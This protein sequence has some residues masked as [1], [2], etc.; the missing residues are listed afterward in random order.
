MADININKD[1]DSKRKQPSSPDDL[2]AEIKQTS[3]Q[4]KARTLSFSSEELN[5]YEINDSKVDKILSRKSGFTFNIQELI[6]GILKD[7]S[8]IDKI[9]PKICQSVCEKLEIKY[10]SLVRDIVKPLEDQ[11]SS[12]AAQIKEQN[13]T[14]D[15]HVQK[16]VDHE[17]MIR[18]QGATIIE[19]K[20]TLFE[21]QKETE[22]LY[23]LNNELEQRLDEQEQYSRRTSLRFHNIPCTD[24]RNVKKMN[25]DQIVLDICNKH[26]GLS[27]SL[28]DIGRT[29]PIG[30][31]RKNKTQVIVRFLSYRQRS[32]VF[33]A[34]SKLKSNQDG[35]FIT[36]NLTSK[37]QAIMDEL[38]Y[39]R[40]NKKIQAC[41]SM[42]GRLFAIGKNC[43]A[44]MLV[45]SFDDNSSSTTE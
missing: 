29:H 24:S 12:Q 5:R 27:M 19:L 28:N 23:I 17:L 35:I 38:N 8:F 1:Y 37:R 26:L 21:L 42:D 32:A 14:I 40:F 9:V 36:E 45:R 6:C 4:T 11:V 7:D 18:D 30:K 34:K 3:R 13:T 22:D 43:S 15:L 33:G 39:L 20:Q 2:P 16:L 25:T 41:W 44:T 31:V 10:E